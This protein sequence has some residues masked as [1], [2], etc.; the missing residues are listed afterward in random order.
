[1][2]A[3]FGLEYTYKVGVATRTVEVRIV[4]SL[5]HIPTVSQ[6]PVR[7]YLTPSSPLLLFIRLSPLPSTA[8]VHSSLLI[9]LHYLLYGSRHRKCINL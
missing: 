7:V 1:M 6:L 3:T 5:T 4:N 9:S 2:Q 8:A